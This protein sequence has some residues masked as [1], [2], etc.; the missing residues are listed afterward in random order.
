M[1]AGVGGTLR[2]PV[3]DAVDLI[4]LQELHKFPSPSSPSGPPGAPAY[5]QVPISSTGH[6]AQ[7]FHPLL[8]TRPSAG[9]HQQLRYVIL[10]VRFELDFLNQFSTFLVFHPLYCELV[11]ELSI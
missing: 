8:A 11:M 4:P 2:R 1:C 3:G 9:Q 7:Q 6:L 5:R 10:S